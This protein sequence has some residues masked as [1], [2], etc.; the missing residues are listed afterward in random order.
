MSNIEP[1]LSESYFVLDGQLCLICVLHNLV[2]ARWEVGDEA[3]VDEGM[4]DGLGKAGMGQ[5]KGDGQNG[6]FGGGVGNDGGVGEE[7]AE[8]EGEVLLDHFEN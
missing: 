3:V 4:D 1:A 8:G 5:V 7:K 2:D 6:I